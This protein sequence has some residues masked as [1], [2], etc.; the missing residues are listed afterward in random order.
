MPT[1]TYNSDEDRAM[2]YYNNYL[3]NRITFSDSNRR[4]VRLDQGNV[5]IGWG[6]YDRDGHREVRLNPPDYDG[7]SSTDTVNNRFGWNTLRDTIGD[8]SVFTI[9]N[10]SRLHLR[11]TEIITHILQKL[12]L[13]ILPLSVHK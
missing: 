7:L 10:F 6:N 2:Y 12:E 13:L 3:N 5:T 8:S 1:V 11:I 9:N 4:L